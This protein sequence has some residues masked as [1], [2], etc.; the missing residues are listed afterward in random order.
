[1]PPGG[2]LSPQFAA[3]A[4]KEKEISAANAVDTAISHVDVGVDYFG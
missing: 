2:D 4:K 3:E 1:M